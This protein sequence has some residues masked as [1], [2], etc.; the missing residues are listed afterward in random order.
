MSAIVEDGPSY[1]TE[2]GSG[3]DARPLHHPAAEWIAERGVETLGD[4]G[5]MALIHGLP[6]AMYLVAEACRCTS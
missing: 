3:A 1:G 2:E 6:V 5:L 4:L